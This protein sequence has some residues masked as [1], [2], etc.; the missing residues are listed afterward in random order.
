MK[1]YICDD[2]GAEITW[3]IKSK[4]LTYLMSISMDQGMKHLKGA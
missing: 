1:I 4:H 3:V 2:D